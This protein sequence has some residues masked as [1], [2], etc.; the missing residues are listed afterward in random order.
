MI[1]VYGA[2]IFRAK[3]LGVA[4]RLRAPDLAAPEV[5]KIMEEAEQRIYDD[6]G[7][8]Y[9]NTGRT[10]DSLVG[11]SSDSIRWKE[12]PSFLF[13]TSVWYAKFQTRHIGPETAAGGMAR[14]GGSAILVLG[15]GQEEL[16][17]LGLDEF[18]MAPFYL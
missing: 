2:D 18:F 12:G 13:G 5:W 1:E 4:Q 7:G 16:L 14:T 3:C 15:Y 11:R 17:A 6:L 10:M 8:Y 9:V